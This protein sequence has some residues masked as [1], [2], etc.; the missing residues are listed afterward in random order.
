MTTESQFLRETRA[1]NAI[2]ASLRPGRA[3]VPAARSRKAQGLTPKQ[4]EVLAFLHAFFADNDQ[5]PPVSATA[6]HFG[7]ST[8]AVHWHMEQL[9]HH[10][11]IERNTVGRWRFARHGAT[12]ILTS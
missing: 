8:G 6:Q 1:A 4:F 12:Q 11:A 5:I 3:P 2:A 9:L 10:G 7:M